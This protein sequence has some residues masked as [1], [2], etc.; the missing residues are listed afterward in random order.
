MSPTVC[1]FW[2]GTEARHLEAKILLTAELCHLLHPIEI[3]AYG[4]AT[5]IDADEDGKNNSMLKK[6]KGIKKEDGAIKLKKKSI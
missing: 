1:R 4:T 2:N 5:G 3:R 6:I